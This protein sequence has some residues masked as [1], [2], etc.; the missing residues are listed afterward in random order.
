MT[1]FSRILPIV[2]ALPVVLL[3]GACGREPDATAV[4]ALDPVVA[5]ALADPLMTDPQLATRNPGGDG[6]IGLGPP[7]GTVP[8]LDASQAEID[9]AREAA[10]QAV[11]GSFRTV[12]RPVEGKPAGIALTPALLAAR[13]PGSGTCGT[14][15]SYSAI[16]AARLPEPLQLYPRAHVIDAAG[17]DA[18][19]CGLRLVRTVTPVSVN[20]AL[21]FHVTRLNAAGWPAIHRTLGEG[22]VLQG[23]SGD[24]VWRIEVRALADGLT[25]VDIAVRTR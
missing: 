25:G 4:D 23:G 12:P 18:K 6:L 17:L 16:W 10:R 11:G 5:A 19:D 13:L 21:S 3:A 14:D 22:S 8:P 1:G 9:R 15:L 7:D 24:T 20:D 2:A